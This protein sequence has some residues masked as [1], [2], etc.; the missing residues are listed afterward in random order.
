M[1]A[2]AAWL[3]NHKSARSPDGPGGAD[4]PEWPWRRCLM[5]QAPLVIAAEG[6]VVTVRLKE[7][8]SLR[9]LAAEHLG[10]PDLWAEILRAERAPRSRTSA[11][12]SS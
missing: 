3:H 9:D 1:I 4:L 11:R 10:D 2:A 8:Q 6:E 12:A 7:G 5:L